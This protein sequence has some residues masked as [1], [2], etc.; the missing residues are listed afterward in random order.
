MPVYLPKLSVVQE[1]PIESQP[2]MSEGL[3]GSNTANSQ[4]AGGL[5]MWLMLE[6]CDLGTLSVRTA[7][8][9]L[10]QGVLSMCS[11]SCKSTHYSVQANDG[12]QCLLA[13][14]K[15][16]ACLMQDGVNSG[17][18]HTE[19]AAGE[20][21]QKLG[22]PQMLVIL[23]TAHDIATGVDFIHSHSILHGDL[24]AGN[25]L[26]ASVKDERG[27]RNFQAKVRHT[28]ATTARQRGVELLGFELGFVADCRFWAK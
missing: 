10:K 6:F 24:T 16:C 15:P 19:L 13:I 1:D 20:L 17:L 21:P 3:H 8:A 2:S 22:V 7:L 9:V 14:S 25:V 12:R 28:A 26:L 27:K 4:K 18:F 11:L 5:V 23:E